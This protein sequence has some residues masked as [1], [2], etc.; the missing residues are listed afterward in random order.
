M[1]TAKT[2]CSTAL[3][4]TAGRILANKDEERPIVN[5][6]YKDAGEQF[7]YRNYGKGGWVLHM[8]R[9]QLGEDLY[10]KCV[11]ELLIRYGLSSAVT[12]DFV[13]IIEEFSGRSCDRFFDQFVRIGRFPELNVS[14]DWIQKEKLAKIT[15]E[16]TQKPINNIE[17]YYFPVKIPLYR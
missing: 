10:R 9:C 8:L 4:Q 5:K 13:S 6:A 3:Y 1:P 7:D 2:R 14:Y 12:E 16:Q 11:K 15:I 17:I